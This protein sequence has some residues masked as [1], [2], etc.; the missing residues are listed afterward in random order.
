MAGQLFN[1]VFTRAVRALLALVLLAGVPLAVSALTLEQDAPVCSMA[2]CKDAT[3]CCCRANADHDGDSQDKTVDAIGPPSTSARCPDGCAL[4]GTGLSLLDSAVVAAK[5]GYFEPH[6][7]RPPP[8][9][10]PA[11]AASSHRFDRPSPRAPP[12][13]IA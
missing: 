9:V 10:P 2:C 7:A 12:S 6:A 3:S 1:A 13:Q 4:G 8:V 5:T 11:I